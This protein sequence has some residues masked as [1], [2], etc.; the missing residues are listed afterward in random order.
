M[1]R[2]VITGLL[3]LL[4]LSCEKSEMENAVITHHDISVTLNPEKHSIQ[5]TDQIR[6]KAE[7]ALYRV[8][9]VL[10]SGYHTVALKE[11]PAHIFTEVSAEK[12]NED[13][14]GIKPSPGKT[15][16]RY[17]VVESKTADSTRSFTLEFAGTIFDSLTTPKQEY[18]RGFATTTGLI[19]KRGVYLAGSSAWIPTQK[20]TRFTY[21]LK[22]RL[23]AGWHSVSQGYETMRGIRENF[24]INE[25]TCDKPME[26]AYL[27]AGEY[28]ITEEDHNG[29]SVLTYTYQEEP[30]LTARYR[31]ATKRYLDMYSQKIGAY[32]F[33]K[34]ALVENFWQ[35][36]YGMPSFTLLGNRIIRLPFIIHTSY[37]HEILHNWWGNSVYVDW[38]KGNWCEGLT[39]YM[40]DHY[41]KKQRG[42]DAEYR[43]SM[44]Q[45]Y[46]NYVQQEADFP[47]TEF[48][49]RHNPATQAVGYS[50]SA[51]VFH[52]LYQMLGKE[53]FHETVQSF[54]RNYVFNTASWKDVEKEFAAKYDEQNLSWFFDQWIDRKG[55]P[56]LNIE[57]LRTSTGESGYNVHLALT[58]ETPEYRLHVPVRFE[59]ES[60]D[61][62]FIVK[63]DSV[64]ED[65][66]F[67]FSQ[68]PSNVQVDPHFDVFR[69]LHRSEIPPSLSQTLGKSQAIIAL[70]GKADK[71]RYDAYHSIAEQWSADGNV[72][73]KNDSEVDD[74]ELKSSAVWIMDMNNELL[75]KTIQSED[76]DFS[77]MKDGITVTGENFAASEYSFAITR[78]NPLNPE[79][80]V[81]LFHVADI[82]SMSSLSRKLPHYGKYGYLVFENERNIGKGEWEVKDS[83]LFRKVE[84]EN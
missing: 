61:T 8:G 73:I 78:R 5:G 81:T 56:F 34:F 32:P 13:F 68:P 25:W 27:I 14:P 16:H 47:L 17:Y 64:R 54:Y 28:L 67:S 62:T 79:L 22:T 45:N 31:A 59:G 55:A 49:E 11:S 20:N 1:Y 69:K 30:D 76:S 50:K 75:P 57:E 3:T 7:K 9:F 4:F 72:V 77:I 12:F 24:Q 74:D 71:E 40:A 70:P 38:E 51:M 19:E 26:E 46:L 6:I 36:G 65:Y 18:S 58:Q 48:T 66:H 33:R 37:G 21:T 43:R 2:Y 82:E 10:N 42:A 35:T 41:Y 83:P 84:F 60:M 53:K 29:I 15:R 39:N 52:M 80:S 63:L 23:P 44:L